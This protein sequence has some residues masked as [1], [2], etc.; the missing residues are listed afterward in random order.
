MIPFAQLM[1]ELH[2]NNDKSPYQTDKDHLY[3]GNI[4][5]L[6]RLAVYFQKDVMTWVNQPPCHQCN[7]TKHMQAQET[8][9][10]QSLEEQEGQA[11]RVEVY[12][13]QTCSS[14]TDTDNSPVVTTF[15]R[16]NAV[17][18]LL[19]TRR[20]RC[21][22]YANLFGL[23]C[24]AAGFETRYVSDWTDH[25]W[26][27]VLC[28][29]SEWV[30]ADGCEGTIQ[31]PSMYEHGW[32]KKL[33]YMVAVGSGGGVTDVTPR[34][35]RKFNTSEFQERRRHV[36]TSET[37]SDQIIR[38]YHDRSMQNSSQQQH[39]AKKREELERRRKMEQAQLDQW[40]NTTEWTEA[41]KHGQGRL[42]GS[43]EWRVQRNEIGSNNNNSNDSK[44]SSVGALCV[45][46]FYPT[47]SSVTISVYPKQQAGI[48]VSGTNCDVGQPHCI[49]VVVVDDVHLGCILQCRSFSLWTDLAAFLPIIPAG[50][51]VVLKGSTKEESF[52]DTAVARLGEM[53][54]GFDLPPKPSEGVMFLGRV[55]SGTPPKWTKCGT[56]ANVSDTTSFHVEFPNT[57][58]TRSATKL[59]AEPKTVARRVAGR[60]PE[61]AMPLQTQLMATESQKRVAFISYTK[62]NPSVTGYTSKDGC[63]IYLLN[64]DSFPFLET[65]GDWKTYHFLPEVLVPEGDD[66]ATDSNKDVP[67]FDVPIEENFFTTVLGPSLIVKTTGGGTVTLPLLEALRYRRLIALYFSGHWCGPCRRFTPMLTEVYEHLKEKFEYHGVEVVFVSS[68]R[69]TTEFNQYYS[70]MPWA[71][72]PYDET[73][74]RQQGISMQFGVRG[75]P[76]M[77]VLDAISGQIVASIEQA[78]NEVGQACSR[79]DT[80]IEAMFQSWISRI[81]PDSR[82][83][84]DLMKMSADEGAA[85]ESANSLPPRNTYLTRNEEQANPW[86]K[87]EDTPTAKHL[88][89]G[90][91]GKAST[92]V[93]NLAKGDDA[94]MILE[95]II[96]YL[97]NAMREPWNPKFRNFKMS[98]KIVDKAMRLQGSVELICSLGLL[99]TP[100]TEDFMVSIPLG[101]DLDHLHSSMKMVLA[102][103]N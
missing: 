16:Y 23:Y 78:R 46:Q 34:Y 42:S 11:S 87:S 54:G 53:L 2:G 24:R 89:F 25:V 99:V 79:G 3:E 63:P 81:P 69:S 51:I 12:H 71:A 14:T 33:S 43:L 50:R 64:N 74:M 30:M 67:K 91:A 61:S 62:A 17:R 84:F 49:S 101:V 13:C 72:V 28:G 94:K 83:L 90:V 60:L 58:V 82:E 47:G 55:T 103:Q 52:S 102:E 36:T 96:K 68:D 93:D 21:G 77:V 39:N 27:E 8:R 10:P 86:G 5:F 7:S 70:S 32:G 15:P 56:Y 31:E 26:V 40:K 76:A 29:G 80:G 59:R 1:P 97:H 22:E 65:P 95:T 4:L 20:G 35:T 37:A 44:S 100:T 57:N 92:T 19:E 18:K 75:I 98:N 66:G 6:K 88:D 38:R 9:G 85:E 73:R 45:E 41:E 48:L